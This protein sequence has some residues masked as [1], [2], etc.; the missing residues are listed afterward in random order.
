MDQ[1]R[2]KKGN[3]VHDR[4]R[5]KSKNAITYISRLAS[6]WE[7]I[8]WWEA[9]GSGSAAS[10][11]KKAKLPG[12]HD[13]QDFATRQ[14]SPPD[15]SDDNTSLNKLN[16]LWISQILSVDFYLCMRNCEGLPFSNF[17]SFL[18]LYYISLPVWSPWYTFCIR[19]IWPFWR[20]FSSLCNMLLFT[21]EF[22]HSFSATYDIVSSAKYYKNTRMPMRYC[23]FASILCWRCHARF[24]D[25]RLNVKS[26]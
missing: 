10:L 21:K 17:V 16:L 3:Q 26:L 4:R 23:S 7:D 20:L 6:R 18:F 13:L 25:C 2:T 5:E 9:A 22:V 24:F 11:Q 15:W 19:S 12:I 1:T 8:W 14:W